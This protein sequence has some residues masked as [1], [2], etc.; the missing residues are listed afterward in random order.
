MQ[1]RYEWDV[2]TID[3]YGDVQEHAHHTS[4]AMCL[5]ELALT[6]V[7]AG[8]TRVVVLVRD[9]D[10]CRSWAYVEAGQLPEYLEDAYQRPVA[11]V[12]KRYI[13]EVAKLLPSC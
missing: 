2:E 4:Y 5:R 8:D 12:P 10:R 9:D 7:A 13:E 1:V 6:H 3:A 11:R